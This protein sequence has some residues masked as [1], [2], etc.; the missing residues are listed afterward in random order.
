MAAATVGAPAAQL[1]AGD[2]RYKNRRSYRG[3]KQSL[4]MPYL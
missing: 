4:A 2:S 1:A 3:T